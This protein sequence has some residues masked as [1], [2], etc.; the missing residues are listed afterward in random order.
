MRRRKRRRKRTKRRRSNLYVGY[1]YYGTHIRHVFFKTV[2]NFDDNIIQKGYD[3][4]KDIMSKG[5]NKIFDYIYTEWM[6]DR[7]LNKIHEI[8]NSMELLIENKIAVKLIGSDYVTPT[9]ANSFNVVCDWL[10]S[11]DKSLKKYITKGLYEFRIF[12][13]V[14]EEVLELAKKR[15]D[16]GTYA[17][18]LG[19]DN[20]AV[21]I[22]DAPD[23]GD[24]DCIDWKLYIIGEKC[25]KYRNKILEKFENIRK[26][27]VNSAK[28][29]YIYYS[30]GTKPKNITFKKFDNMV[31]RDSESIL[32]YVDNWLDNVPLYHERGIPAKLS[33]LLYGKPG[34]GKSSFAQALADRIGIPDISLISPEYF[35]CFDRNNG[36]DIDRFE[37]IYLI[38]EIDCVCSSREEDTS[39]E[40]K[41]ALSK[42]LDFLD[43]PPTT[44]IKAK[45][46][47]YYNVS[48]VVA[49]TNYINKL[50][51]AVKR[52]GRF[53]KQIELDEFNLEEARK[54]CDIF[55]VD[56]CIIPGDINKPEFKISPAL[57]QALCIENIDKS[58]KNDK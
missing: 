29:H 34:T 53:D 44:Y 14:G 50:D 40:N 46:G 13:S 47:K 2:I 16:V 49:T 55:G 42:L 28:R 52:H 4:M 24:P 58:F 25:L 37:S 5:S 21:F 36:P 23:A 6:H 32:E 8:I 1:V 31:L 35:Y 27:L 17:V 20:F 48:V 15:L 30:N 9:S 56:Y 51:S 54:L 26:S 11:K 12:A 57:L 10:L 33:I 3:I 19:K 18:D 45:D 39:K 43:N 41:Q 38:D 7:E 22:V